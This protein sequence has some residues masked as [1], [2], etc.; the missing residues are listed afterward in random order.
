MELKFVLKK[1]LHP[2]KEGFKISDEL[3]ETEQEQLVKSVG[4]LHELPFD[5]TIE[6]LCDKNF[7]PEDDDFGVLDSCRKSPIEYWDIY[8][9]E[10]LK[11]QLII[12]GIQDGYLFEAN[13]LNIV[14]ESGLLGDSYFEAEND[15]QLEL[16]KA[17][18]SARKNAVK[19]YPKSRLAELDFFVLDEED[20]W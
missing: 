11:Q 4:M 8:S 5:F 12:F 3:S 18:A 6:Q 7:D 16:C 10:E 2:T 9:G 20:G 14:I 13:T 19:A 1:E 17:L 15:E